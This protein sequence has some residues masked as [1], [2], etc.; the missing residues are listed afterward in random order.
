MVPQVRIDKLYGK[1]VSQV[2]GQIYRIKIG[3]VKP[4]SKFGP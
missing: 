1:L 4:Y 3:L 2:A